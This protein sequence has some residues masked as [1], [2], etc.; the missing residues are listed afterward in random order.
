MLSKTSA[1][2]I[3]GL[4]QIRITKPTNPAKKILS[5]IRFFLCYSDVFQIIFSIYTYESYEEAINYYCD[6]YINNKANVSN[7]QCFVKIVIR[8]FF[9]YFRQTLRVLYKLLVF[10]EDSSLQQIFIDFVYFYFIFLSKGK[11]FSRSHQS[12]QILNFL[13]NVRPHLIILFIFGS[14]FSNFLKNFLM[15]CLI[16]CYWSGF[17]YFA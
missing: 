5:N 17:F 7:Y 3:G 15:S 13:Y 11:I 10:E 9:L 16:R 8:I 14:Y 2:L 6:Y 4:K 12:L 1:F